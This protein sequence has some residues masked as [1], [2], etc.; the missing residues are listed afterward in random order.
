MEKNGLILGR[1][2]VGALPDE[3]VFEATF[4]DRGQVALAGL[5]YDLSMFRMQRNC[6]QQQGQT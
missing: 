4:G 5:F 6:F 1:D 2:L 3:T